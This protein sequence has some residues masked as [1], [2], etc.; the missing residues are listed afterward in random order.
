MCDKVKARLQISDH[1]YLPTGFYKVTR[2]QHQFLVNL[3]SCTDQPCFSDKKRC[4][5]DSIC[6]VIHRLLLFI[7]CSYLSLSGLG[8]QDH[9]VRYAAQYLLLLKV[10]APLARIL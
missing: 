8:D 9:N 10:K 5:D 2:R 4:E 1:I 6:D 3:T 7:D